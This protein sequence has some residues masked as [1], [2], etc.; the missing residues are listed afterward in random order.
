VLVLQQR[1][2]D[3][4]SMDPHQRGYAFEEWLGDAFNL[5]G[6]AARNP[7]RNRG[8]QIDGSFVLQGEAYLLEAKWQSSPTPA[9][10]LR[11]FHGKL[12]EK[13]AWA[14]GLFVSYM[15]FSEDGLHAVGRGK[16]V[17]C[18]DGRDF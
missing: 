17:I 4:W 5:Y 9:A 11:A 12:D 13:D 15:G 16:R 3:M 6:M 10:D 8:E 14:R 18:M 7:F 1:L 2:N